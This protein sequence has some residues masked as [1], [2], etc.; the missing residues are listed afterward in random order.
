MLQNLENNGMGDN[1]LSNPHPRRLQI[2]GDSL[3]RQWLCKLRVEKDPSNRLSPVEILT[4]TIRKSHPQKNY[5]LV[6]KLHWN[7]DEIT[8]IIPG[9]AFEYSMPWADVLCGSQYISQTE[10]GYQSYIIVSCLPMNHI[11]AKQQHQQSV[12]IWIKVLGVMWW[13]FHTS[14][15]LPLAKVM[16]EVESLSLWHSFLSKTISKQDSQ[17]MILNLRNNVQQKLD[18]IQNTAFQDMAIKTVTFLLWGHWIKRSPECTS[19]LTLY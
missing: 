4:N 16:R 5:I 12:V 19:P 17:I 14:Y 7:L 15:M 3:S 18:Q 10:V 6:I 11:H 9:I 8:S 2:N 1:G 13:V